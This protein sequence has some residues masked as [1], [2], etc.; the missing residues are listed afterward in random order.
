MRRGTG[1]FQKTEANLEKENFKNSGKIW[2][3]S[4]TNAGKH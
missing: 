4:G 2:E 1:K 3:N